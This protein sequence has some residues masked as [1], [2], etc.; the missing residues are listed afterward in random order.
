MTRR[1][2]S[3]RWCLPGGHMEP[4]ESVVEACI[5][6]CREET[7][8]DV[9]V[10]RL[11]GVHGSPHRVIEY[12]PDNRQQIVALTFEVE[13]TGGAPSLSDETTEIGYFTPDQLAAMDV[14]E[15]HRERI[16]DAFAGTPTPFI[17]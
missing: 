11:I 14:H 7:G 6:E 3:G 1:A 15:H 8:L 5:R 4:G 10:V 2:D 16:A 12:A 13:P 9:R 17:R